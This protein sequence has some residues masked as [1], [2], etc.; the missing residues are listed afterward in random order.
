MA[1][2][3][4]AELAEHLAQLAGLPR[5]RHP[6]TLALG[7]GVQA[8]VLLAGHRQYLHVPLDG[9]DGRQETLAVEAVAVELLG[10]LVGGSDNHHALVEQYLEQAAEDDRVTDVVDE[11]LVEAQ[12][13]YLPGQLPGQRQQRVGGAV[14]LEQALVDPG[15]EV[16]EVLAPA[17][18]PQAAVEL[19]HQPG[20]A[21][22]DRAPEVDTLGGA[23]LFDGLETGLQGLDGAGL[24]GVSDIAQG[25]QGLLVEGMGIDSHAALSAPA[26]SPASQLPPRPHWPQCHALSLWELAC[27]R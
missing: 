26:S 18:Y 24:G 9:G 5:L 14:E 4:G 7:A 16:V 8:V 1:C 25:G 22:A 3:A 15:H 20:L 2:V 19:V 10:R 6:V 13:G 23:A 17:G 21:A 27:R 12:H 11:Q